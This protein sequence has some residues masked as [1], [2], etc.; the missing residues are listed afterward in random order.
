MVRATDDGFPTTQWSLIVAAAGKP[1]AESR[2]ALTG[3]CQAYWYPVYVQ[4]RRIVGDA[5][6]ARDLTQDFFAE[7]L[8]KEFIAAAN[9]DLGRF[10]QFLRILI[11]RHL[12]HQRRRAGT[13][14][15][16]GGMSRIDLDFESAESSYRFEQARKQDPES[17][18]EQLWA[19]TL[20]SRAMGRM[21]KEMKGTANQSRLERLEPFLTGQPVEGGYK[22]AAEDLG[23]TE[24]AVKTAVHRMRKRFGDL[25]RAEVADT[26]ADTDLID[27]EI[28]YLFSVLASS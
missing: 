3:I 13:L 12:S 14:K 25:L 16:G 4:I 22:Q 24:A 15:R 2:K 21:R 10:R 19:R 17:L 6:T 11:K 9:P 23:M 1:S 5:E 18:F 20:L 8:E 7:L 27:D 26:V 28:R